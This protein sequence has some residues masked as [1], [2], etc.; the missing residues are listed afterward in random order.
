MH[1]KQRCGS[2]FWHHKGTVSKIRR[3]ASCKVAVCAARGACGRRR[4]LRRWQ[5]RS[6]GCPR[7]FSQTHRAI[8]G[9]RSFENNNNHNTATAIEANQPLGPHRREPTTPPPILHIE[10]LTHPRPRCETTPRRER[11]HPDRGPARP[12]RKARA[13]AGRGHG[14]GQSGL[15]HASCCKTDGIMVDR[16]L[17][18]RCCCGRRVHDIRGGASESRPM[19]LMSPR[20]SLERLT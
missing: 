13:A 15:M 18:W 14:A 4:R 17:R 10:I 8:N 5:H 3:R 2:G 1:Q 11:P 19:L 12:R 16:R 9:F 6:G 20:D 7:S